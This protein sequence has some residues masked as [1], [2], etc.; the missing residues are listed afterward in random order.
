MP[1]VGADID[2]Y[3]DDGAPAKLDGSVLYRIQWC[4]S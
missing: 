3:K 1:E 4:V 2:M